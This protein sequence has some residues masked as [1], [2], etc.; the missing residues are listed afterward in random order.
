MILQSRVINKYGTPEARLDRFLTITDDPPKF[1][2]RY[3][4]LA[5]IMFRTPEAHLRR[6]SRAWADRIAYTDEW[7]GFKARN[8]KEWI[9]ILQLVS[10]ESTGRSGFE[11]TCAFLILSGVCPGYVSHHSLGPHSIY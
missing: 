5:T 11:L 4:S 6:C 7:R 1:A 10:I 2:G 3:E 9:M 8:E